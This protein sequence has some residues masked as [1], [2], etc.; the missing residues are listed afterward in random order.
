MSG[1][2]LS[3]NRSDRKGAVKRPAAELTLTVG[4]GVEGDAHAGPGDRQVSLLMSESIAAARASAGEGCEFKDGVELV[5]GAF[6]ENLTTQGLD[7][8]GL[9]L[10]DRL[11]VGADAVLRVSRIGKHCP[12]PCA[13]YYQ[14]GSCIMPRQGIFGEV[15][16][17]GRVR[18]GDA[19]AK[20]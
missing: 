13:I 8:L 10:G 18:P 2:I 6:A 3:V 12:R 7:L 17:G 5:P 1:R 4:L 11:R 9:K 15:I 20:D 14:L 16:V 19:I